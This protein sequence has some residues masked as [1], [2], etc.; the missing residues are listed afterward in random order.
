[1]C[2]LTG[3]AGHNCTHERGDGN[4]PI[5]MRSWAGGVQ[6]FTRPLLMWRTAFQLV[7]L[8][9]REQRRKA[10]DLLEQQTCSDSDG[11]SSGSATPIIAQR[12]CRNTARAEGTNYGHSSAER[13][14]CNCVVDFDWQPERSTGVLQSHQGFGLS[15]GLR[16]STQATSH[17]SNAPAHEAQGVH[18]A[19]LAL[20]CWPISFCF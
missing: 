8:G 11:G 6:I 17:I 12:Q 14:L 1:V 13:A 3:G 5:S 16:P 20:S 18:Q 19:T 9:D 15:R 4:N 10:H 7:G 2:V